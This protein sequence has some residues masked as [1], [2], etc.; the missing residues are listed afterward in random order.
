MATNLA[1]RADA[2]VLHEDTG[3][4]TNPSSS[5]RQRINAREDL[6]EAPSSSPP[7]A[8]GAEAGNT[9]SAC[10]HA[11]L[12]WN[13]LMGRGEITPGFLAAPRLEMDN[14][15]GRGLEASSVQGGGKARLAGAFV[16]GNGCHNGDGVVRWKKIAAPALGITVHWF[17]WYAV[18]PRAGIFQRLHFCLRDQRSFFRN[19]QAVAG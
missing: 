10:G 7:P 5:L 13:G 14:L 2:G 16:P 12:T 6:K 8:P 3:G 19:R 11:L 1:R 15:T 4:G 17:S 9:G 18:L